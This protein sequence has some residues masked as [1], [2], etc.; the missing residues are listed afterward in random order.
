MVVQNVPGQLPNK[1]NVLTNYENV[2][3]VYCYVFYFSKS[4]FS[5]SCNLMDSYFKNV[6]NWVESEYCLFLLT[7]YIKIIFQIN[8]RNITQKK[9]VI[10]NIW[11]PH[12]HILDVSLVLFRCL[13]RSL[14]PKMWRRVSVVARIVVVDTHHVWFHQF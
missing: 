10:K 5:I 2:L 1:H 12:E 7:E 9:L 3:G 4:L 13:T 14:V 11:L 6:T 8:H